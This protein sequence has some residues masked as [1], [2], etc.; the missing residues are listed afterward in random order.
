MLQ[1]EYEII[2]QRMHYLTL[3]ITAHAHGEALLKST[4]LAPISIVLVHVAILRQPALVPLVLSHRP[5][6]EALIR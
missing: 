3:T 4:V 2:V 6:E 1:Y 5:L